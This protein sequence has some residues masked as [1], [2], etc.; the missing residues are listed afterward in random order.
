MSKP[1][2]AYVRVS[3]DKQGRSGLGEEAQKAAISAFC[4]AHGFTL[5]SSF[6]E[7]ETAKGADALER[8]PQLAA[9]L[10]MAALYQC[11]VA[12]AKLDRLSRDVAFIASLMA[13]RIP[14]IV[15]EHPNAD[16]FMLHIYA[17]VA[18]QE[19]LKISE[20]TKAALAAA[21]A[22][23]RRLGQP[24]GY[25]VATDAGRAK[26]RAIVRAQADAHAKRLAATLAELSREGITSANATATALNE[27]KILAPRGGRWTAR[28]VINVRAR[29]AG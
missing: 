8:R 7:V 3:T 24:K 2:V 19:R 6:T 10:D 29:L 11:P 15:T 14:F 27:R 5:V 23:G 21:R 12:V 25:Q 17:A 1:I 18:E 20:R 26:A 13:Q 4:A 22:R 28:S 9:A 16:P